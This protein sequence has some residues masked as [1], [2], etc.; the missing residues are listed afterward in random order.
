MLLGVECKPFINNTL[1]VF[2]FLE[3]KKRKAAQKKCL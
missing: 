1:Y 2:T 3:G